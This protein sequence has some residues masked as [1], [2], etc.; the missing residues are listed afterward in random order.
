MG[1]NLVTLLGAALSGSALPPM[2][3]FLWGRVRSDPK[4]T[5]EARKL[6]E[7]AGDLIVN[8]L[9][10]EIE[11]LDHDVADLR[12]LL[13]DERRQCDDRI[14][15]MEGRIRQLQQRQTSSGNMAGNQVEG[16]LR[17]AFP[18]IDTP[19]Q[20]GDLIDKIDRKTGSYRRHRKKES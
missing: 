13:A 20:D 14:Q 7:E 12:K 19:G 18:V 1:S 17:T 2:L 10:A 6:N 9:Y 3:R 16:P 5:A 15:E 4:A 11:R 8:R